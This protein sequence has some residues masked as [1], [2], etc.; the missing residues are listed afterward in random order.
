MKNE[1]QIRDKEKE[2]TEKEEAT[3]C[4]G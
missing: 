4:A 3:K 2:L 1:I